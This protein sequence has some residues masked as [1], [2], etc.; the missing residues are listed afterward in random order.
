MLAC[1][2]TEHDNHSCN[3]LAVKKHRCTWE[4]LFCTIKLP[5]LFFCM[6]TTTLF[7]IDTKR[8]EFGTQMLFYCRPATGLHVATLVVAFCTVMTIKLYANT[9]GSVL[10]RSRPYNCT[11]TEQLIL[12]DKPMS[13]SALKYVSGHDRDCVRHA[14][15]ECVGGHAEI[16]LHWECVTT[17][18][19]LLLV[20][21]SQRLRGQPSSSPL[22]STLF[23]PSSTWHLPLARSGL[24]TPSARAV[25][26]TVSRLVWIFSTS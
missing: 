4:I 13:A 19:G 11:Q 8:T 6:S 5:A 14:T 12:S 21:V 25:R 15:V 1:C 26:V 3:R 16:P 22:G 7:C 20:T 10:P 18:T 23:C 24:G 17:T 9:Y 2:G